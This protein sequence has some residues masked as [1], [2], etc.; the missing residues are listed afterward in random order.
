MKTFSVTD[1]DRKPSAVLDASESDGVARVRRRDG[2]TYTVRPERGAKHIKSLP[3]FRG[4][5]A[6]ICPQ[7]IPKAQANM[8][9]QLIAGDANIRGLKDLKTSGS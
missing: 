1:L 9:D 5:I 8:V 4:R 2:R 3:D 7:P 6:R